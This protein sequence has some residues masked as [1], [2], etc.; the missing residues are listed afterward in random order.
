MP[1]DKR[2]TDSVFQLA[3]RQREVLTMMHDAYREGAGLTDEEW[4]LFANDKELVTIL[5]VEPGERY[6]KAAIGLEEYERYKVPADLKKFYRLLK[7]EYARSRQ[8]YVRRGWTTLEPED[9]GVVSTMGSPLEGADVMGREIPEKE[10][11]YE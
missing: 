4:A 6:W 9:A 2:Q 10:E 5:G 11:D 8:E 1:K 3:G 7:R